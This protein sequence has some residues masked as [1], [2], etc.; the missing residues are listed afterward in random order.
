MVSTLS[1]EESSDEDEL[2]FQPGVERHFTFT[3]NARES[4]QQLQVPCTLE[5]A[6]G[7]LDRN[8]RCDLTLCAAQITEV[9]LELGHAPNSVVFCWDAQ[10]PSQLKPHAQAEGS[11]EV[12]GSSSS[13][14][15]GASA[16]ASQVISYVPISSHT[17]SPDQV[18]NFLMSALLLV[19][20]RIKELPAK[21]ALNVVHEPPALVNEYYKVHFILDP[22][23][24]F[25]GELPCA[26]FTTLSSPLA[27]RTQP[28]EH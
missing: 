27:A 1:T 7:S 28:A 26:N 18:S 20:T 17:P 3:L 5:C 14:P 21:I 22:R 16:S 24:P 23:P 25:R 15:D 10:Q 13:K 4:P 9:L 19:L 2:L 12:L 6:H 8:D 11:V